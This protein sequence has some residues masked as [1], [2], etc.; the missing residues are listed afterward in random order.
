MAHSIPTWRCE[1]VVTET[2]ELKAKTSG[3]VFAYVGKIMAVGGTF[4]SYQNALRLTLSS[5]EPSK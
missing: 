1:G 5:V 2:R 4:E 3:E